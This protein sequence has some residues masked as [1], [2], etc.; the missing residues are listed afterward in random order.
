MFG[1][2]L[3]MSLALA[4]IGYAQSSLP[5]VLTEDIIAGLGNN[6]LFTRWRP[7][8]HFIAPGTFNFIPPAKHID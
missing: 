3:Y 7:T 2:T 4:S 8:Y 6:S 1:S 5:A